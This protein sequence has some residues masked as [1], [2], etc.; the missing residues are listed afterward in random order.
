MESVSR[1]VPVVCSP[2]GTS[3]TVGAESAAVTVAVVGTREPT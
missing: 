2:I 1:R 3:T